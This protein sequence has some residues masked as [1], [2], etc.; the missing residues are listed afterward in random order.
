MKWMLTALLAACLAGS[1]FAQNT[2]EQGP[3]PAAEAE[4]MTARMTQELSLS[5]DQ[6]SAVKAINLKYLEKVLANKEQGLTLNKADIMASMEQELKGV[7]TRRNSSGWNNCAPRAPH[8][9]GV[10]SRKCNRWNNHPGPT[11]RS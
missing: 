10:R 2:K 5:P 9:T 3:D 1:S 8:R 11:A 6:A 7:L 4:R